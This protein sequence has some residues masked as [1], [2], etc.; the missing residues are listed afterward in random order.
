MQLLLLIQ[1]INHYSLYFLLHC[2]RIRVLCLPQTTKLSE[3]T[4]Q[5][6]ASGILYHVTQCHMTNHNTLHTHVV[7]QHLK[8]GV[9]IVVQ[10]LNVSLNKTP[11]HM[12]IIHMGWCLS[13]Q[14][15]Y[16]CTVLVQL[17]LCQGSVLFFYFLQQVWKSL[18]MVSVHLLWAQP[19]VVHS[20]NKEGNLLERRRRYI[21]H[22][23]T[24]TH[25]HVYIYGEVY[26]ALN[27][28]CRN[29][30]PKDLCHPSSTRSHLMT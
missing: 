10:K 20:T 25:I 11:A 23:R 8:F 5:N 15:L 18:L 30:C 1:C 7:N 14:M 22:T 3:T 2:S 9:Q 4:C 24:H 6:I 13:H 29:L 28:L 19:V 17:E 26:L 12:Y 16:Y 27:M 21:K